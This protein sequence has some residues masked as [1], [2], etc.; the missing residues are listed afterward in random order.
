[1]ANGGDPLHPRAAC[2][3]RQKFEDALSARGSTPKM[4]ANESEARRAELEEANEA[5]E[6]QAIELELSQQQLSEQAAELERSVP[7]LTRRTARRAT[8][9]RRC[10]TSCARR[11]TRSAATRSCSRWASTGRSRRAARGARADRAQPA[12]LLGLINDVLELRAIEAGRVEY[13]MAPCRSRPWPRCE[14]MVEPQLAAKEL[15]L[16]RSTC[17]PGARRARRP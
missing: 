9:S 14:P 2:A 7:M 6:Q 10:A 11:S 17:R 1:M 15:D 3:E 16:R 8:S 4:P 5:L 12:H 13:D